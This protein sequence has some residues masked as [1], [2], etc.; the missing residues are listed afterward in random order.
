MTEVP[1]AERRPESRPG[2]GNPVGIALI[3]YGHWGPNH[4]RVFSQ[5]TDS[6]VVAVADRDE[7]RLQAAARAV[8]GCLTTTQ[9][10]EVFARPDVQAVVIATPTTTH[11]SLV[12][13]AL[14][15]GKDVLVEK[16]ITYT[17]HEAAE[18][19]D[20]ADRLGRILM[21]GH[22]FMYNPGLQKVRQYIRDGT[23]GRVYYMSATRTNLGPLRTDVNAL[24][25]LGSHDVSI[26]NYLLDRLP[27]AAAA[28][29]EAYLQHDVEDIAFACLEYPGRT[30]CHMHVSWLNPLKERTL[31]VV[32][33]KK[34]VVWD[35]TR[36]TESVRLYDKG[37]MEE[38]HYDSFGHFH[39]VLRDA[40]VL[41]PKV[42]PIEPLRMQDGH[43]V[44]CVRERRRPTTDG[45]FALDV[46]VTL[47]ALQH[48]LRRGGHRQPVVPPADRAARA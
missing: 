19:V 6:R 17:A 28:W 15:A 48:S 36:P 7:K 33:D 23:L 30:L 22:V 45:R 32:G 35:D 29:G 18:L 12:K 11:H 43:F 14:A 24:F 38:P 21:C 10:E 27:V 31:V 37:L 25:D 5:F 34:M 46:M 9:F 1:A 2:D 3:G 4:A 13:A 42:P 26:F 41:I 40:D 44:E 47:D 8:P 16:P 39:L 20:L